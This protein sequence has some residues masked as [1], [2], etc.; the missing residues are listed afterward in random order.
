VDF[1][2]GRGGRDN[3]TVAVL[4]HGPAPAAGGNQPVQPDHAR[5]ENEE[6]RSP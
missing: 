5:A 6:G 3:I 1:A 4:R 2:R